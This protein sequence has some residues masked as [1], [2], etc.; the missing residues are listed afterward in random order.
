MVSPVYFLGWIIVNINALFAEWSI[1]ERDH[2]KIL[3]LE[4]LSSHRTRNLFSDINA[5]GSHLPG[6]G[7]Y[8]FRQF[9]TCT[10]LILHSDCTE[11]SSSSNIVIFNNFLVFNFHF[12]NFEQ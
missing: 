1:T 3:L 7:K 5:G 8:I 6:F 4:I 9:N 2:F 12:F 10:A 11:G